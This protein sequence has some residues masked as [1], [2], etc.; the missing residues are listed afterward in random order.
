MIYTFSRWSWKHECIAELDDYITI[1]TNLDLQSD[2]KEF[3]QS[4]YSGIG[5]AR[6][7]K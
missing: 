2:L 1:Q 4:Q 7:S 5:Q 6:F 3:G